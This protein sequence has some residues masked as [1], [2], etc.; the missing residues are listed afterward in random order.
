MTEELQKLYEEL[1]NE[2]SRDPRIFI[3]M[4]ENKI[5]LVEKSKNEDKEEYV[6]V[7]KIIADYG[8]ALAETGYFSKAVQNLN[9][10]IV[11][12]E[13][14]KELDISDLFEEPIYETSIFYRGLANFNLKK[15]K[16][17]TKD[18]K[19]LIDKFPNNDRYKNWYNGSVDRSFKKLDWTF[20]SATIVFLALLYPLRPNDGMLFYITFVGLIVCLITSIALTIFK[21]RLKVK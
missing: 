3:K 21:K 18:F 13:N 15:Y 11:R 19:K 1:Y 6:K 14:E 17:S 8:S 12:M 4:L 7:T 16:E 9:N 20:L 2:T 10:A 5:E